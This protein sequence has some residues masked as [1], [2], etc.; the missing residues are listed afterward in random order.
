[1]SFRYFALGFIT[2]LLMGAAWNS[3]FNSVPADSAAASGGA[4]TIR[5]D[6][7]E[8]RNRL[9][10]EHCFGD[11]FTD[12]SVNCSG[13]GSKDN[14]RHREGS[15]LAFFEDTAPTTLGSSGSPV[16]DY[17]PTGGGGSSALEAGRL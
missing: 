6:K 4:L 15:A 12:S 1:M 13:T 2:L 14:G 16:E 10:T 5:N 11:G 8:T 3:S 17:D 9:H 7:I